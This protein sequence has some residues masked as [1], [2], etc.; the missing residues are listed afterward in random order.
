MDEITRTN[1]DNLRSEDKE[2]QGKAFSAIIE[3]TDQPVD[4]AYDVWDQMVETWVRKSS[5]TVSTRRSSGF[6]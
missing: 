6:L 3:A 2:V 5:T 1:F 4:W